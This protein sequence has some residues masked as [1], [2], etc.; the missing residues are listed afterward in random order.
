VKSLEAVFDTITTENSR[1]L[2]VIAPALAAALWGGLYV[3]SMWGFD[4]VPPVTLAFARV[5]L[6]A[7][8]LILLVQYA[9]PRRTFTAREWGGFIA[10][11]VV[12]AA[13]ITTQFLGTELTTASQ[14]SLITVSTPVFAV[15][16]GI[17]VLGERL[18]RRAILGMALAMGGT[19]LVLAGQYDLTAL[20]GGTTAGIGLLVV[21]SAT[22]AVYTVFG[23]P[24]VTRYS[25]LETAAY[26]ATVATVIL[27]LGVPIEL[28]LTDTALASIPITLPLV[29]AVGY[30]GVFGTAVAWYLWYKGLEYVSASVVSVFLF[31]QPVVGGALGALF[32][33]EQ[34]G[35][36]FLAG[37]AVMGVGV[38]FLSSEP[39]ARGTAESQRADH[40]TPT[41]EGTDGV[42]VRSD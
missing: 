39:A 23:K 36:L 35:P 16:L 10:L 15:A 19:V 42:I 2:L 17:T 26:S 37:G 5:G 41:D 6:G 29:L 13:S 8:V 12:V 24:L 1:F 27:A 34:L 30:L 33:G 22:W 7:A 11:G 3:V 32:L 18:E 14:G 25:A 9:Y 38:W 28:W 31:I 21:A 20:S 4:S 40:N